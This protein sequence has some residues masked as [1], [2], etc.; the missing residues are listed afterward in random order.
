MNYYIKNATVI[1]EGEAFEGGVYVADGKIA[2][3]VRKGEPFEPENA[4]VIDARDKFLQTRMAWKSQMTY[5][6]KPLHFKLTTPLGLG[7]PE[8]EN[9]QEVVR[10]NLR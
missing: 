2:S 3:I 10:L 5:F 6:A 8:E 4:Q 9:L 7:I 1:N